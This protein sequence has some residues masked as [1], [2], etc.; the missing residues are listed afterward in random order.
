M[1]PGLSITDT[2]RLGTV[3]KEITINVYAIYSHTVKVK[4]KQEQQQQQNKQTTVIKTVTD[5]ILLRQ[6][7]ITTEVSSN[8]VVTTHYY[9]DSFSNTNAICKDTSILIPVDLKH[10]KKESSSI[11]NENSLNYSEKTVVVDVDKK[12]FKLL[13]KSHDAKTNIQQ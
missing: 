2:L 4:S 3:K 9:I 11:D 1:Y 12:T 5:S 8:A 6:E 7:K 13:K 10:E